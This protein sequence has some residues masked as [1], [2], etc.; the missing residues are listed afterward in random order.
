MP[1]KRSLG[2][3]DYD[4]CDFGKEL[5][6]TLNNEVESGN[7]RELKG[8]QAVAAALPPPPP[9]TSC[10]RY[11]FAVDAK[12]SPP[13]VSATSRHRRQPPSRTAFAG[14]S[15]NR[16][17]NVLV[18]STSPQPFCPPLSNRHRGQSVDCLRNRH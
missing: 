12:K 11:R 4:L 2:E 7:L 18:F 8:A 14:Q 10:C 13:N 17:S 15:T 5:S 3:V 6:C 16:T 9:P 1:S